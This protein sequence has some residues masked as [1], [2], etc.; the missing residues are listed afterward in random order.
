MYELNVDRR[1]GVRDLEFTAA[2]DQYLGKLQMDGLIE[3][4]RLLRS[5]LGLGAASEFK[6]LIETRNLAQLDAA[7][8][9]VST[10]DE[11]VEGL[12]HGVNSLVTN[13]RAALWRDFPDTQRV[14]GNERF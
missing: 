3:G 10:R 12:H 6:V 9:A 14:T 13:F 5:K 1:P 2:L 11:P 4:W 8:T 7:F